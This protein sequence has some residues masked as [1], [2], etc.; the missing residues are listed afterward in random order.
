MSQN[1][2]KTE[3]L[4]ILPIVNKRPFNQ[5]KVTSNYWQP[6][7]GMNAFCWFLKMVSE[8]KMWPLLQGLLNRQ[9]IRC[10]VYNPGKMKEW[11]TVTTAKA[12]RY[13]RTNNLL[14][15]CDEIDP[16]SQF[17]QHFTSTNE[18]HILEQ[19]SVKYLPSQIVN[20]LNVLK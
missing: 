7:W 4:C 18:V 9:H 6:I 17:H 3:F 5:T 20:F 12:R 1:T 8:K 14:V 13:F 10:V 2:T 16:C 19:R 11:V 15:N